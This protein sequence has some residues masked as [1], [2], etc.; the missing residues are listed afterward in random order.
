MLLDTDLCVPL[1]GMKLGTLDCVEIFLSKMIMGWT[2]QRG[3]SESEAGEYV[4]DNSR[5]W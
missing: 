5:I 4:K 1:Q 3:F 2:T